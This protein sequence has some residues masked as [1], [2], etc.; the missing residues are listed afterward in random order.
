MFGKKPKIKVMIVEDDSLLAQ[1]LSKGFASEG[2]EAAVVKDGLEALDLVIKFKPAMI[3]LD[4]MLPGIDGFEV[5]KRLKD[6]SATASIPVVI[7]SNLDQVGDVKSAK[8]LGAEEYF[9]KANTQLE[10]IISYAKD[11]IK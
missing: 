5:L 11:K 9:I 3:F 10:K 4:L 7:I 6:D 1:V 8:V 2:F